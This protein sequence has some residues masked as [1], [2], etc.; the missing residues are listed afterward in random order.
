MNLLISAC[1]MGIKCRYDGKQKKIPEL[2]RL[3]ESY[4]LIPVCPEVL[5]GLPTPRVPSERRGEA[6]V[7]RDGRDVTENYRQGARESLRIC[8][9]THTDCALLKERSPSCG[10]G[11]IYDGN[12]T[13]TLCPGDGV[14][15]AL[16]KQHG[17]RVYGESQ[18][19]ELLKK[20]DE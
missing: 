15:A 6:V 14:C 4:V 10:F 1:L 13:G 9:M 12:F 7:T 18:V 20:A 11:S 16:L 19:T 2:D 5:G 3:M 8:Q 17:V